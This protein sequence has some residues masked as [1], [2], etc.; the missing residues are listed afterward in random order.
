MMLELTCL[1]KRL[2]IERWKK[3]DTTGLISGFLVVGP[4]AKRED[5]AVPSTSFDEGAG[6]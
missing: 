5:A 2:R 6:Y 4:S 1:N 3:S